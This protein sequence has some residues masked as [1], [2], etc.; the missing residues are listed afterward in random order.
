MIN[1]A[2]WARNTT[3]S[4]FGNA[5]AVRDFRVQLRGNKPILVWGFYLLAQITIGVFIYNQSVAGSSSIVDAQ[6]N[7][8]DYYQAIIALLAA[9]VAFIAPAL[10]AGTIVVER[11]RQ[12][13]DLILS[14]PSKVG[15]L[16]TGKLIGS[17]RYLWMLLVLSLP[18]TATCVLLGGAAWKDVFGA[19]IIL[20]SNALVFCAIGLVCSAKA[21]RPVA[22]IVTSYLSVGF[23][24]GMSAGIIG[25]TSF[26][27]FTGGTGAVPIFAGLNPFFAIQSATSYS[28]VFGYRVPIWLS[29]PVLCVFLTYILSC[30]AASVLTPPDSVET[31]RL[32]IYAPL[33]F[34][35]FTWLTKFGSTLAFT[36][37]TRFWN[38]GQAVAMALAFLPL[39]IFLPNLSCYGNDDGRKYMN[40]GW[41]NLRRTFTGYRSGSL[42]FILLLWASGMFGYCFNGLSVDLIT[43]GLWILSLGFL[44]YGVGRLMSKK[45]LASANSLS[46][47]RMATGFL[48]IILAVGPLC[49]LA[50]VGFDADVLWF[51]TPLGGLNPQIG[52][53]VAV[54]H[55]L[56]FAV[57]GSLALWS[58]ELPSPNAQQLRKPPVI[59]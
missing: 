56:I 22:A 21:N 55:A 1:V 8:R 20:S 54:L 15:Y 37:S 27:M 17:F 10:T 45:F 6:R 38:S 46:T 25:G 30:G 43:C 36:G 41:F 4:L 28:E 9:L 14:A 39:A 2:G 34:F 48:F 58:S 59:S 52:D 47:A 42:P 49:L 26:S 29:T 5:M 3:R 31:R 23:A 32:R 44:V 50:L 33:L 19:F 12:S 51:F 24:C 57:L 35:G 40:D 16:L 18:V 11:Q 13:L 7:L 53:Q